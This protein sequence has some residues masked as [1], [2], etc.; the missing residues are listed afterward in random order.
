VKERVYF[1]HVYTIQF[2]DCDTLIKIKK[3]YIWTLG[4]SSCAAFQFTGNGSILIN[5]P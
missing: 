1:F 2:G 4:P 5:I 3:L